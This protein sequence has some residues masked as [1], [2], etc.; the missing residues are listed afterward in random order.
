MLDVSL[1]HSRSLPHVFHVAACTNL[2]IPHNSMDVFKLQEK[3]PFT[4]TA[5]QELWEHHRL[6]ENK[7][8]AQRTSSLLGNLL[9]KAYPTLQPCNT[10]KIRAADENNCSPSTAWCPACPWPPT[11]PP[12]S[13][14]AEHCVLWYRICPCGQLRS[15]VLAVIPSHFLCTLSPLT[16]AVGWAGEKSSVLCESRL[17]LTETSLC[18]STA[19]STDPNHSPMQATVKKLSS[20]PGKTSTNCNMDTIQGMLQSK[21]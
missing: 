17:P 6:Q 7:A 16:G 12:F 9:T 4:A 8:K 10:R 5:V 3:Q 2:D 14:I 15:V 13:F 18:N 21:E 1:S 19:S 20:L 11:N